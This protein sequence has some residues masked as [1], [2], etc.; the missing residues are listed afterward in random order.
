MTVHFTCFYIVLAICR[1]NASRNLVFYPLAL[2][3]LVILSARKITENLLISRIKQYN[4][5]ALY[6][7]TV[8][9]T[10]NLH[11]DYIPVTYLTPSCFRHYYTLDNCFFHNAT[12]PAIPKSILL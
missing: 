10:P 7:K 1:D 4:K 5:S 12:L 2:L 9:L 3:C 11:I 6:L 8:Q